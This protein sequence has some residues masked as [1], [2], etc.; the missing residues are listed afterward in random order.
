M[1]AAFPLAAALCLLAGVAAHAHEVRPGFLQL[2]EVAPDTFDVLWKQPV[3]DNRRLR[4]DP[5]LPDACEASE[6]KR[7]ERTADALIERW[8]VRCPMTQ[9]TIS[10]SGLKRTLTD[11]LV[12]VAYADGE[13]LSQLLRADAPVMDLDDP[14]VPVLGY[15]ILGIEHL[16]FGIDHILFVVGLVLLIKAPWTLVKTVTAFTLAHSIT[17]ALSVLGW[18]RLSQ[19]PVEVLIAISI[20]LL[21]RE[22]AV[23]GESLTR[24]KPWLM[25]FSFGLLHGFGFAGALAEIGLP[26]DALAASLLF[27]N[28]GLELGQ[29]MIVL[30]LFALMWLIAKRLIVS[31]LLVNAA[32]YAMG[33][34]AVYWTVDRLL[35]LFAPAW[36]GA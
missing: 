4:I 32:V 2:T 15:L 23:P 9:G 22:L 6:A 7:S 27:F 25:A 5:M 30:P 3:M 13:Q 19:G 24:R 11:I 28:V 26:D 20:V 33:G 36:A 14:E 16:L 31:R 21:A 35:P 12:R 10:V 17:L 29:L 34:V 18:V 8:Q 1:K